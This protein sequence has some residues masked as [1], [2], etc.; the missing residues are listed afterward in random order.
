MGGFRSRLNRLERS[1]CGETYVIP[2]KDGPP[3]VFPKPAYEEAWMNAWRCMGAGEDAEDPHPMIEAALN[4]SDP[5]WRRRF[6]FCDAPDW[7]EP[8]ADTSE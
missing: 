4:S 7:T 5:E 1:A 2:Q 3:K 6:S 8:V